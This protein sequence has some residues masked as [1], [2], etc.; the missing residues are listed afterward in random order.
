MQFLGVSC[1]S[2][3]THKFGHRASKPWDILKNA[4]DSHK[5]VKQ[6]LMHCRHSSMLQI[7]LHVGHISIKTARHFFQKHI[8]D[9][10][11]A[12]A[13]FPHGKGFVIM[14]Q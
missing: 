4:L 13:Y 3:E 14:E 9:K 6:D 2:G 11:A 8:Q 10:I 12:Q 1:G 5:L 7:E